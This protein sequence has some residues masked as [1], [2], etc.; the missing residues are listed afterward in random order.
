MSGRWDKWKRKVSP[1]EEAAVKKA[2]DEQK[3]NRRTYREVPSGLYHVVVDKMEIGE[4][5]WGKDQVNISFK[6]TDGDYK[7]SRIFYNGSFDDHFAHGINATAELIAEMLDDESVTAAMIAVILEH[8]ED[9][10][11]GFIADAAEAVESLG[12]DLDYDIQ[13]SKKTNPNTGKPYVNKYYTIEGVY[14]I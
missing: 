1:K 4:T 12:Y 5:T 11:A 7:N 14:D 10:A 6:V 2:M 8:G 9:E 13:E 3:E